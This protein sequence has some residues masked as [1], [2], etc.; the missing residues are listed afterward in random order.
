MS[1]TAPLYRVTVRYRDPL[2]KDGTATTQFNFE[3]WDTAFAFMATAQRRNNVIDAKMPEIV[4]TIF[5]S[6]A[7]AVQNLDFWTDNT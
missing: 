7:T 1:D 2:T 3:A 5:K 6:H 4:G